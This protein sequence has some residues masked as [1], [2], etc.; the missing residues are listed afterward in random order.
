MGK[1]ECLS[2]HSGEEKSGMEARFFDEG[3]LV[4]LEEDDAEGR[5]D[6]DDVELEAI[7]VAGWQKKNG[8]WGV[9]ES[10]KLEVLRQHH[11]S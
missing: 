10:H 4:Y 11:D 5:R 1:A 8:L 3:Q 2:R 7:D 6:A 9:S